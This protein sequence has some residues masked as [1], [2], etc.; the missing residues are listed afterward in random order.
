MTTRGLATFK[1]AAEFLSVTTRTIYRMV[2]DGQL[3]RIEI[4][5]RPRIRWSQLERMARPSKSK[6]RKPQE[7]EAC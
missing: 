6:K 1:E 2:E 5:S 3:D 4:R 7:A